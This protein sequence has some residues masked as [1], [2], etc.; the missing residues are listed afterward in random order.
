[1]EAAPQ[2]VMIGQGGAMTSVVDSLH[3]SYQLNDFAAG[4]TP[5]ISSSSS[6]RCGT[7]VSSIVGYDCPSIGTSRLS[8][9]CAPKYAERGMTVVKDKSEP[10]SMEEAPVWS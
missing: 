9:R 8:T 3:V 2:F 6:Q 10:G 7:S 1:M 4:A 5:H